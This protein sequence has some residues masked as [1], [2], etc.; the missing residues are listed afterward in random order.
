M[1]IKKPVDV[2]NLKITIASLDPIEDK[3]E[4]LLKLIIIDYCARH[5]KRLKKPK[6]K[7]SIAITSSSPNTEDG[8]SMDGMTYQSMSGIFVEI[9]SPYMAEWEPNPYSDSRF[10]DIIC[11]EFV[12]VAQHLTQ[13]DGLDIKFNY[14]PEDDTERYFFDVCELDARILE[15]FYS[16]VYGSMVFDGGDNG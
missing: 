13:Y 11:H 14:D 6:E 9:R 5:K 15:G 2:S 8:S 7:I 4:T 16:A 1:K 3:L 10:L 12:H